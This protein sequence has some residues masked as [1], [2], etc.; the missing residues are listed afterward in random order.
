MKKIILPIITTIAL[1]VTTG[2][3]PVTAKYRVTVDAITAPNITITPHIGFTVEPLGKNTDRNSLE[4][5][6]FESKLYDVLGSKGFVQPYG[7]SGIEQTIYFD[8]GIEKTQERTET[9]VE[10]DVTIGM[11][12]GSPYGFYGRHYH[13]YNNFWYGGGYSTTY[14]KTYTYYNR[15]IT[16]LAKD[17]FNKE[18]WRVDVSSIGE[19]KN[20]KKIVPMLLEAAE[21]YIG[22][23]TEEPVK[24]ILKE[25]KEEKVDYYK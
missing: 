7:S 25:K 3:S 6:K 17:Q 14:R 23:N 21:D 2:C 13:P 12:W 24:L 18:L 9:Y 5:Q 1:L 11:S 10:P 4:Y 20:L 8:Y 15:Y 22:K 16:L 19:S